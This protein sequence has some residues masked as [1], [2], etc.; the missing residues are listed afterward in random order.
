[1][2]V[3]QFYPFFVDQ[4][5]RLNDGFLFSR[6]DHVLC[7]HSPEDA[8]TQRFDGRPPPSMTGAI[9][10]PSVVSQ[11]TSVTTRSWAT[12]TSRRVR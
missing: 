3:E 10:M 2:F 9:T 12:S 7:D 11:S 5:A 1:M 6:L 4:R 8:I